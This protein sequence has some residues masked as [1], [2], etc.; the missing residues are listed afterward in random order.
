[1]RDVSPGAPTRPAPV[2][3]G[4]ERAPH[5]RAPRTFAALQDGSTIVSSCRVLIVDW[6]HYPELRDGSVS[7][8]QPPATTGVRPGLG[9]HMRWGELHRRCTPTLLPRGHPVLKYSS[10][11]GDTLTP[12]QRA[13]PPRGHPSP[14]IRH[15]TAARE[16]PQPTGAVADAL[17]RRGPPRRPR[18]QT[19][20]ACEEG[21][22]TPVRP[23]RS[24]KSQISG[25]NRSRG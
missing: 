1:M 21:R 19:N 17:R 3:T 9:I 16:D 15:P 11:L 24:D 13:E 5:Y 22:L 25:K 12:P 6:R 20:V 8:D 14:R 4:G 2:E 23:E 7:A 18:S 10:D